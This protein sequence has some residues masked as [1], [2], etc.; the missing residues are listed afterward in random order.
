MVQCIGFFGETK[1]SCNGVWWLGRILYSSSQVVISCL[2]C[3]SLVHKCLEA[4][5]A[6][7]SHR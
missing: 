3:K 5:D 4:V 7:A 2:R 6:W 1:D